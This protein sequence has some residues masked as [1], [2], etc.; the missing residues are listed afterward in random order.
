MLRWF[1]LF[2]CLFFCGFVTY[3]QIT[4]CSWN[5][6]RLGKSTQQKK[7]EIIATT[8]Q[9][10]DIIAFQEITIHPDAAT[11]LEAI[12]KKL[13]DKQKDK[14]WAISI[15]KVTTS[16]NPQEQERYA[17]LY[18]SKQLTLVQHR[19]LE[20]Y[21]NKL[22]REPY[23]AV[24]KYNNKNLYI[25]NYHAVPKGKNPQKE[26]N[27]LLHY[28]IQ[29]KEAAIWLGDFNCYPTDA[30]FKPLIANKLNYAPKNQATTIKQQQC[31]KGNC[32][33]NAYDYFWYNR[34]VRLL[35]SGQYSFLP[36]FNYDGYAARKISD[37]IPVFITIDLI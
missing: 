1:I 30:V 19:L 25:I 10:C 24:F 13:S 22:V 12:R 34:H 26:I 29:M 16:A 21:A 4:I 23:L 9:Q 35:A 37:H 28:M 7:L 20:Q 8:I 2:C 36:L 32:Y 6:Q 15:S 17:F 18:D 33:A 31:I 27:H 3:A 5:V 11:K 14:K